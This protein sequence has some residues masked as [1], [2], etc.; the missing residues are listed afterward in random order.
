MLRA[1]DNNFLTE[2][3]TSKAKDISAVMLERFGDV[4][5]FVGRP[6]IAAAE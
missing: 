3:V 2:S 1:E 5:G 4:A 6:R